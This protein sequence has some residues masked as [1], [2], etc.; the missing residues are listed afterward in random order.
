MKTIFSQ[1]YQMTLGLIRGRLPE[2][3]SVTNPLPAGVATFD[4]V[5][6]PSVTPPCP[7]KGGQD[8]GDTTTS[9]QSNLQ[10]RPIS[11][12]HRD[13]TGGI[14][15]IPAVHHLQTYSPRQTGQRQLLHHLHVAALDLNRPV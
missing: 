5:L 15:F 2:I 9:P 13:S 6:L 12:I 10:H 3:A 4:W 11:P 14:Y 1:L 8:A 7:R